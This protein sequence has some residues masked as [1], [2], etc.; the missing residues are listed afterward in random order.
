MFYA[1]PTQIPQTRSTMPDS[2]REPEKATRSIAAYIER[3]SHF[4]VLCPSVQS[5]DDK[6]VMYDYGTWLKSGACRMELF[7]L[8][9]ARS[10]IPAVVVQGGEATP[11]MISPS[12]AL[13]RSPGMGTL[14]CCDIGHTRTGSDGVE[15][16]IPCIKDEIAL[17]MLQ[18][19][20]KRREYFLGLRHFAH[21]RMWTA[22]VPSVMEGL[23]SDAIHALPHSVTEFVANYRFSGARDEE[24][25]GSGLTP[26]MLA[27]LSGNVDV[28]DKLISEHQ[29]DVDSGLQINLY[30]LGAEKGATALFLAAALCPQNSIH[31]IVVSLLRGGANP[32]VITKHG[33]TPLMAAAMYQSLEG[34]RALLTCGGLDLEKK[35]RAN[36]ATALSIAS[37]TSTTEIVEALVQA[38][39]NRKHVEDGGGS[40]LTDAVSNPAADVRMLEVICRQSD[41]DDRS[42]MQIDPSSLRGNINDQM[43]ARTF[44]FD[45]IDLACRHAVRLGGANSLLVMVRLITVCGQTGDPPTNTKFSYSTLTY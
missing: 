39:A 45:V 40:K 13:P 20:Q 33:T 36:G 9:L 44:K 14:L 15:R 5:R 34:T 25:K 23:P 2:Q 26:L 35:L 42:H 27:G 41:G 22:L 1:F 3:S 21:F 43:K 11:F 19:L 16:S 4:F 30:D 37:F 8:L 18:M 12:A 10:H 32:N 6:G 28:V 17:V 38:G 31:T 7:A 24:N 29:V